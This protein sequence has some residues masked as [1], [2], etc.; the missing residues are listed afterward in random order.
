[1]ADLA[2]SYAA[3]ESLSVYVGSRL[4]QYEPLPISGMSLFGKN[5]FLMG[6]EAFSSNLENNQT[7]LHELYRLTFS[8]SAAGLSGE[9]ATQETNAA[10]SFAARAA[11]QLP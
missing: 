11:G 6:S 10:A 5:G 1:M 7:V 3:G 4:I 2:A 8:N 9:L